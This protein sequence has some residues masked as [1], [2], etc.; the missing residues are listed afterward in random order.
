MIKVVKTVNMH[1]VIFDT[2]NREYLKLTEWVQLG[3]DST[4]HRFHTKLI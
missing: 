1:R 4:L 2:N 3:I